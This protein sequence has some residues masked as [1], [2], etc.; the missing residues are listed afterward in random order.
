MFDENDAKRYRQLAQK[1]KDDCNRKDKII[2]Q[3]LRE[4]ELLKT[5]QGRVTLH[6]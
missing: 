4:I 1:L 2:A 3:Q 6:G 5:Q